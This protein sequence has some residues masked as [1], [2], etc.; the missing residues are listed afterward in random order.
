MRFL[1]IYLLF[2]LSS[3]T[4]QLKAQS[5]ELEYIFDQTIEIPRKYQGK[6]PSS[7]LE[8]AGM[9]EEVITHLLENDYLEATLDS[10]NVDTLQYRYL[11]HIHTGPVYKFESLKLDSTGLFFLNELGILPPETANDFLFAR[12]RISDYYATIG[13]P[14]AKVRLNQLELDQGKINARLRINEGPRIIMDSIRVH[15]DVKLRYGY[16]ENYLNIDFSESYNHEDIMDVEN[17]VKKLTFLELEKNPELSF[18]YDYAS[19]DLYVKKK[20]SSRFDLIFGV[21][22]TNSIEGKQLFLSMDFTAE[23][24]NRMGYGEYLFIDFERLRPEQQKLEVEFNYPYLLDL[25]YGLDAHFSIFR[26]GFDYQT[27]RSDLGIQYLINSSDFLKLYWNIESS[28]LI[29]LDT[30]RLKNTMMLPEDLDVNINGIGLEYFLT[31]LDYKFNPR[32]GYQLRVNASGGLRRI[33]E[34]LAILSLGDDNFDFQTLYD[35]LD[36]E[37]PR[38]EIRTNLSC[39]YPLKDRGAFA[40]HLNGGWKYSSSQLRRNEKFQIG[41]N[42]LLRGFDEASIF[43]SWYGLTTIEYRLLLSNNSYFSLPFIDFA[44]L[45]DTEGDTSYALGIGGSLGIETNVGL[46]NFSI[47]VGRTE[48]EAF[49]FSRPK[50]HFGFVSLF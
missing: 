36:L 47:A 24:L 49:D 40:F 8:A 5:F 45:E 42:N 38:F 15:G 11:A 39:Y 6:K 12:E 30:T 9:S 1:I 44:I 13:Y 18:F 35:E 37:E 48:N 17:K 4:V 50:A 21:I 33:K 10:V 27:I 2:F 32:R 23:M 31:R 34:N 20:N 19:L 46:F 29:D 22:P 14:F 3:L 16:W 43:T 25:P 41:G 7:M 28:R 26:N